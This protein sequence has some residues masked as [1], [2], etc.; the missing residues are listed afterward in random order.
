MMEKTNMCRYCLEI[1]PSKFDMISHMDEEHKEELE[2]L[3]KKK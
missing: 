2:K 1:F 3:F